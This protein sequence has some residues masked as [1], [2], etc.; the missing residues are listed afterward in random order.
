MNGT[1]SQGYNI[2]AKDATASTN[3]QRKPF[4][5]RWVQGGT[6]KSE[7]SQGWGGKKRLLCLA[8]GFAFTYVLLQVAFTSIF[9][10]LWRFKAWSCSSFCPKTNAIVWNQVEKTATLEEIKKAYR[11]EAVSGQ[12]M[13]LLVGKVCERE[14]LIWCDHFGLVWKR[15][16]DWSKCGIDR[17]KRC[18]CSWT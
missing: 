9:I 6:E 2:G 4:I 10:F 12:F 5:D 1:D 3:I 15:P 11:K 13:N 7:A 14:L 17:T 18:S 16:I 8:P